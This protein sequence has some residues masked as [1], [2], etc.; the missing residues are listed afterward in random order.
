MRKFTPI[1]AAAAFAAAAFA[2]PAFAADTTILNVS[3]DPTRELYKAVNAAFAKDW[4]AKTGDDRHH[5]AVAW[6]FR[7]AGPRRHRRPPGRRR[8]AR[9]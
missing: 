8:D 2:V 5:R 4:K 1:L 3:Y 7:Q 6:R 9:A